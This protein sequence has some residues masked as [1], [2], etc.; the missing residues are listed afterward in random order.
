MI[1]FIIL[2]LLFAINFII[3]IR[4]PF[5]YP[6]NY[7]MLLFFC[8][9]IMKYYIYYLFD[10]IPMSGLT[11]DDLDSAGFYLFS[12]FL[13]S[14]LAFY[15]FNYCAPRIKATQYYFI[16]R[17]NYEIAVYFIII[18][19][20]LYVVIIGGPNVLLSPL[21]FRYLITRKGF[22]YI[23]FF[24]DFAVTFYCLKLLYLK[25]YNKLI[26]L[27]FVYS[28]YAILS[29]IASNQINLIIII[30]LFMSLCYRKPVIKYFILVLI[31]FAPYVVISGIYRDITFKERLSWDLV[32]TYIYGIQD[33]VELFSMKLLYRI[34]YLD[35]F[36]L[37]SNAI[38]LGE[39]EHSYG[40]HMSEIC[41]QW[42]PR[43]LFPEKP[44]NFTMQMTLTFRPDV[45]FNEAGNCFTGIGE[46]LFNFGLLG[47]LLGGF[48]YGI[49]LYYTTIIWEKSVG[50][51]SMSFIVIVVYY[52]YL[53]LSVLSGFIND[54]ALPRLLLTVLFIFGTFSVWKN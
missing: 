28:C 38:N 2:L 6:M 54:L 53:V 36:A 16:E 15:T 52:P 17:L 9:L 1:Y 7:I 44:L 13:T 19:I 21:N 40:K 25:K 31:I 47:V 49:L 8:Y 35:N 34:D 33:V 23:L 5:T 39:V 29:G 12:F 24:F 46:L 4:R 45:F 14:F 30:L 48:I 26:L 50:S 32:S 22:Y 27:F 42:I 3:N 11:I 51:F 20:I 41:Y 37:L 18:L 10:I 43:Y